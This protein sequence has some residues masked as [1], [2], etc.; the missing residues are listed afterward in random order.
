ML[1]SYKEWLSKDAPPS[2]NIWDYDTNADLQYFTNVK[3]KYSTIN[4]KP[5]QKS[6]NPEDLYFCSKLKKNRKK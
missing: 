4:K 1:I 6:I 5:R 2:P 3:S